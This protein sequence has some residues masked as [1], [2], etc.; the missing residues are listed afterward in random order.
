[1]NGL[2]SEASMN[3][4]TRGLK[5]SSGNGRVARK[6]FIDVQIVWSTD[7]AAFVDLSEFRAHAYVDVELI[8]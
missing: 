6:N 7:S 5:A 2:R 4:S 8:F 1:M 3:V